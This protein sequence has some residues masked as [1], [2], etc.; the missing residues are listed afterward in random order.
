MVGEIEINP[1]YNPFLGYFICNL[2]RFLYS[3][4]SLYLYD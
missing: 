1:A 2:S 4:G 3:V